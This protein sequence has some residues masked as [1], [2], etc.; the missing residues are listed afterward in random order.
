MLKDEYTGVMSTEM[1]PLTKEQT[2]ALLDKIYPRYAAGELIDFIKENTEKT[3]PGWAFEWTTKEKLSNLADEMA[4]AFSWENS[5]EGDS[6]WRSVH[7]RL[8][9][10]SKEL[11]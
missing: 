11:E 10:M 2:K 6:Y 3:M 7:S 5:P 8:G 1:K 4:K 9:D